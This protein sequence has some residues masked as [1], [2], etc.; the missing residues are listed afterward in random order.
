MRTLLIGIYIWEVMESGYE[1]PNNWITLKEVYR[2]KR[3][4]SNKNN[5]LSLYHI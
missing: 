5:P 3:K 1:E 2:I 4:E